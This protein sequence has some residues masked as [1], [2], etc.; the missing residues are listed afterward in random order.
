LKSITVLFNDTA[1]Y[2]IP[3]SVHLVTDTMLKTFAPSAKVQTASQPWPK[4]PSEPSDVEY[5][6]QIVTLA[7]IIGI[8]LVQVSPAFADG[9]IKERQVGSSL[10]NSGPL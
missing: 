5:E 8:A 6:Q 7:L 1:V 10:E 9:I 4:P 3:V 2:S